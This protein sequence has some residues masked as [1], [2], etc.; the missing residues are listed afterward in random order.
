MKSMPK[1]RWG[2][3]FVLGIS[4]FVNVYGIWWGL[5][6][7]HGWAADEII[8]SEVIDGINQKFSNGWHSTY[9]PFHYYL[10][11]LVYSPILLLEKLD[12]VDTESLPIYTVLFFLGRFLSVCMGT[13]T[14][15]IVYLT[16]REIYGQ[17]ASLFAALSTALT[18]PFVYYSKT[19]NVEVPYIFWLSLSLFFYIRILKKH[20]LIDYLSFATTAVFSI[21]T[22]DQAYGFYV[23]TIAFIGI[24]FYFYKK[25][26]NNY[27]TLFQC[28]TT[29]NI[30]LTLIA[31]VSAFGLI[32]N[33]AFNFQGFRDHLLLLLNSRSYGASDFFERPENNLSE[34]LKLLIR[35][36]KDIQFSFGLPAS[37]IVLAGLAASLLQNKKNYLLLSL[38]IPAFSY[39]LFFISVILYSRDRFLMPV[40][41]IFTFFSGNLLAKILN[42]S[43]KL[44]KIILFLVIL[45]FCY[46]FVYSFSINI[47]MTQDSRYFVEKWMRQ[48]IGEEAQVLYLGKLTYHPRFEFQRFEDPEEGKG[49]SLPEDL[50][51]EKYDYVIATSLYD[52]SRFAE[53]TDIYNALVLLN[54]EKMGY[55]LILKYQS[56]PKLNLLEIEE[57]S[58]VT[59]ER[60]KT[61]NLNKINPEV[62]VYK[63]L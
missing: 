4:F 1:E 44:D 36:L 55:K 22:K 45:S 57:V 40:C 24:N 56:Q 59:D 34:H 49:S 14:V 15:Y 17:K 61:G 28:L 20:K 42:S 46:S 13:A 30:L 10:L 8:P 37:L 19:V 25:K 43:S 51:R 62:Q 48:N 9:P 31:A 18:C 29:P 12:L 27:L 2:I 32:Y 39:Y 26:N 47:L 53:G 6:S 41:L 7:F 58:F 23:L 38:L 21:C 33:L 5:P 50:K 54:E 52:S 63:K 60:Y 35:C 3:Y 11:A 16:G